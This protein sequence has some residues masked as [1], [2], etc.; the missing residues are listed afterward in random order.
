MKGI[1]D[2][3]NMC[4]I[5]CIVSGYLFGIMLIKGVNSGRNEIT[6]N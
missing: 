6:D 5:K 1:K 3:W 2:E 4:I